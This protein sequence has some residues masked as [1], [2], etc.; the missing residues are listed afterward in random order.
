[1][2]ANFPIPQIFTGGQMTDLPEY[3]GSQFTGYEL[4]EI[5][6][7]GSDEPENA[8]NYSIT[9][10]DLA[11]LLEPLVAGLPTILEDE[12]VYASVGTDSRILVKNSMAFTTDIT[13]AL[14]SAYAQPILVKDIA[15][16]ASAANPINV[17]FTGGQSVDGL[18][19]VSISNPYGWF[20]FNPLAAGNFYAT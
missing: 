7:P 9:T 1:M 15:G 18:T 14:A 17:T 6:S 12:A 20:W 5:V 3:G 11:R 4:L 19:T 10:S 8:V 16:F 2:P 13:L